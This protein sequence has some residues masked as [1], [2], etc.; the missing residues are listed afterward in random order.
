MQ[1]EQIEILEFLR[2]HQPFS[3]LPDDV[4]QQVAQSVDVAYYKAGSQILELGAEINDWFI[5]RS[6]AVEVYRRNGEL[7]NRLTAGGFFGEFGLLRNR[8]VRFP[9]TA[10]EDSLTYLVPAE[11]FAQLFE[12]YEDFADQVEVEDRTRLRQA[13]A[14]R[15]DANELMTAR[16]ETLVSRDPVLLPYT[17]SARMAAQCMTE[18]N[19]SA[20]LV[21]DETRAAEDALVGIVTDRDITDR[22]VAAGLPF[23]TPVTEVMSSQL[24]W[25]AHN[26]LVFE[27][28]LRMLRDNVH[29]LPV[30]RK[31]IP[32]G[33]I[34]LPDIVQYESQNSLFVVRSIFSAQTVEELTALVPHVRSSF[35]RMIAEDANS[36][37]IGSS[38]AVIGRSFKQRLLELAEEK[39]GPPPVPYCFLALGS[40]ARE[41]QLIVT[42]QD[43]AIILD[44]RFNAEQHDDYFLQLATFVADGLAACGYQYCNGGIMATNKT[45]RQP[46]KVWEQYFTDWIEKPTPEFLLNSSIFFDLEGVW[47]ETRWADMLNKLIRSKAQHN[48]RFLACM[49][50]CALQRTPPLGFFKSFVMEVNG[51]HTQSINMKRRGTAPLADLIRVHALSVGSSSRNSFE[52]LQDIIDAKILSPGSGPD[53]RDALELIAMVRIRHQALDLDAGIEPDNNIEPENLSDFERKNLR[54]AFLIVANAQKYLKY[55]Y[56]PGRT[57]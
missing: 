42:D 37:M 1:A 24:T 36:R 21:V 35:R 39:L 18:E 31:G 57:V 10:L 27:A 22:L 50:R 49:A 32:L 2:Q 52:R 11:L 16:I 29:H 46:L 33:V 51:N 40:M 7:Y 3:L 13:V 53:L 34:T 54:D 45:W 14:R 43:N 8:R 5:L 48:S 30:L 6:G 28:M 19:V 55:R 47:G 12:E 23:E 44:N 9:V 25:V 20:L 56:Q 41:E 17:A 26:Q 4:L 15:E 38:M